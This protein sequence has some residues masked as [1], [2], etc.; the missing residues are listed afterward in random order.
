MAEVRGIAAGEQVGTR[1]VVELQSVGE[2]SGDR[3][4]RPAQSGFH[5]EQ[6]A[7]GQ[8]ERPCGFA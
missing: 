4:R 1:G 2:Q 7:S 5:V 6:V 8:A 3:A